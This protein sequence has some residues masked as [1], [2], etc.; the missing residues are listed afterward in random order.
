MS[1]VFLDSTIATQTVLR[2][3][4]NAAALQSRLPAPWQVSTMT[5]GPAA[6]ANL[7]VLFIDALLN[8]DAAGQAAPDAT[9]RYVGFAM[10]ARHAETGEEAGFNFRIL[11]AHP[12][13]I[14]GK[15]KTSRLGAIV[16]E[17]YV[18]GADLEATVTERFRFRDPAGGSVELQLQYRRR[19]PVRVATEGP[20]RS[21]ADPTVLRIYRVDSLVDVVKSVPT[22][23]DRVLSYQLR[24]TLPE[25]ADL[26]DGTERLIAI[27][28]VPWYHRRVFG[29]G[30]KGL[31]D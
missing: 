17:H 5:G 30:R 20:V 25:F 21:V 18:K 16:R 23:T 7:S 28:I 11:T 14:P 13:A 1:E 12:Q 6:G 10:P 31:T 2:F 27:S 8:Q 24:M 3:A 19:V 22:G 4:V 26:F 29:P 9:S 15:Y